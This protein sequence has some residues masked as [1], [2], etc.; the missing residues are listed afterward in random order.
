ME[1]AGE[2]MTQLHPAVDAFITHIISLKGKESHTAKA[3]LNDLTDFF[4]FLQLKEYKKQDRRGK[5]IIRTGTY[6]LGA[7]ELKD[8]KSV[9]VRSWISAL[10]S[11][12]GYTSKSINRKI[13][14]LKSFFK[15]F[16]RQGVIS[17]IP[18][19][20][21][22]SLKLEERLPVYLEEKSTENLLSN[23]T[24]IGDNLHHGKTADK[25]PGLLI[26]EES[27]ELEW[28]RRTEELVVI[29]L[30]LTGIRRSELIELEI[31]NVDKARK[32]IKVLGKGNKERQIPVSV[33]LMDAMMEYELQKKNYL[34]QEALDKARSKDTDKK[35]GPFLLVR[36]NGER[37]KEYFVYSTVK[38]YLGE[39]T[40][41]QKKSPHVLRHT[42]ATH[43]TYHGATLDAVK[44]LLGHSS[45]A[46]TQV[47]THNSIESLKEIH[48]QAHP[49]A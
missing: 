6:Q 2:D 18:M 38:K 3:Y 48:K 39:V 22:V 36:E 1:N 27:K 16:L 9:Y 4:N 26:A 37:L 13:S 47:Y 24:S 21:V 32:T 19:D 11:E 31:K 34:S 43:L 46:A 15:Y 40:S 33:E 17:K 29:I 49:K 5:W 42:F 10:K 35:K 20:R 8:I 12:E 44:E 25:A 45:L 28:R 23:L 30:Y 14:S 7:V 41:Q